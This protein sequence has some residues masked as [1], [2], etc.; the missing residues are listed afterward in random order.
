MGEY[1]NKD[2]TK[3]NLLIMSLLILCAIILLGGYQYKIRHYE[4]VEAIVVGVSGEYNSKQNYEKYV[5][6]EY[7]WQ[8]YKQVGRRMILFAGGYKSGTAA[9]VRVNP[10]Q[11]QELENALYEKILIC[12]IAFL[13]IFWIQNLRLFRRAG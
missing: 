13:S 10:E 8:G 1:I 11:P 7:D 3:K 4:K 6:Y 5:A 12:F 2:R 9:T